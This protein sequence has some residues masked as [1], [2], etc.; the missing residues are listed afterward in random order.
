MADTSVDSASCPTAILSADRL[1]RLPSR[2]RIVEVSPRDGLQSEP[3][4]I[5]TATKRKLVES[6]GRAGLTHIEATSFV[7]AR[8][9]PQLADAY[10]L[11]TTVKR[12]PQVTYSALVPNL[13]GLL[14]ALAAGADAVAVFTSASDTFCY[15][16][17]NCSIA[18]SLARFRPVLA[19]A[20]A[21]RLPV[22]AY[23]SCVAGCP[24]EGAVHPA[25]VARVACSLYK[26]GCS[27]IALA[28]TIGVGTPA[29]IGRAIDAVVSAGVP[30]ERLAVHCHDNEGRGLANVLAAMER[31]VTVIDT[32]VGGLGGCPFAPG[33]A[34]NLPTEDVVA[35]L[36]ALGIDC[37]HVDLARLVEV[38]QMIC[39]VVGKKSASRVARAMAQAEAQKAD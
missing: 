23:I 20:A 1:R 39:R 3:R 15:K 27:E 22:R 6:L 38:A 17:I 31:G 33:A 21:R 36:R 2:V 26:M 25:Q 12:S 19:L 11:L 7:S 29:T 8:A 32:A 28:D 30:V 13:R 34:G 35:M 14:G 5:P 10:A 9:V 18:A 16:N 24:Y 37:G 4:F